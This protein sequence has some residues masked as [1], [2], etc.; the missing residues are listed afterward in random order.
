MKRTKITLTVVCILALLLSS[1]LGSIAYLTSEDR[2]TN[3]FNFGKVEITLD[4]AAIDANGRAISGAPRVQSNTY[5][6]CLPGV[7]YDKDPTVHVLS[8]PCYLRV[9]VKFNKRAELAAI[10][11]RHSAP[12]ELAG[13]FTGFNAA[14]WACRY[15]SITDTGAPSVTV[16]NL[17]SNEGFL[18]FWYT[19]DDGVAAA[20][21][22][23]ALFE[24]VSIPEWLD[25]DDAESIQGFKLDI[26]AQAIQVRPFADA[27]AAWATQDSFAWPA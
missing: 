6:D 5:S 9:L 23:S 17:G 7:S 12:I 14:D 26:I 20:G 22:D 10:A 4:E 19:P 8:G 1:A 11:A 24:G 16:S 2:A 21:T 18:E 13:I 27:A 25:S 3:V 15:N